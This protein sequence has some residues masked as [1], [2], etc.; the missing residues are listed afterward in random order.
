MQSSIFTASR[1]IF[2][3]CNKTQIDKQTGSDQHNQ[4]FSSYYFLIFNRFSKIFFLWFKRFK[5]N[6]MNFQMFKELLLSFFLPDSKSYYFF[7]YFS[8]YFH[9]FLQRNVA[10]FVGEEKI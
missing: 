9:L 6:N 7:L 1:N 4:K 2:A 10:F 8:C 5:T 3:F